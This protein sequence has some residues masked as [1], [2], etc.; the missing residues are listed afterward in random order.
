MPRYYFDILGN[1]ALHCDEEGEVCA[2][3]QAAETE[4]TH[5]ATE[6]VRNGIVTMDQI[7]RAV[8]VREGSSEPPFVRVR[9]VAKLE[10]E[11]LK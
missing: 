1:G 8:E 3:R 6:L 11:R 10:T 5:V 4:A 7:E 2:D 9:A